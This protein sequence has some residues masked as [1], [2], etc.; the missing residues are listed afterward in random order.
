MAQANDGETADGA[1]RIAALEAEVARLRSRLEDERGADELRVRLAQVGAAG[2]LGAPADHDTLLEGIVQTAMH[3]LGARAGSLYLV[4]EETDELIFEVALGAKASTLR[5][6]RI[7]MGRGIA[8]WVAATGQLLAVS[9]VQRDPRWAQEIGQAVDYSPQMMLAMPLLLHDEV[10]GVL[11]LLDKES[12]ESFSAEDMDT[13]GLFAQQAAVAIAQSGTVRNLGA[14]LRAQLAGLAGGGDLSRGATAFLDRTEESAMY[15]ETLQLA[16]T[17]GRIARSGEAGR[18]LSLQVAG[19]IA[20][21]LDA[22]PH[23]GA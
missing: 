21:Y 2:A 10:T 3:V 6:Q 13:L 17:L 12:G 14:L 20:D 7:P 23:P 18:R 9:D 16:E 8:G 19:A 4:D 5:G 15:R 11:Q 1:G 22:Q